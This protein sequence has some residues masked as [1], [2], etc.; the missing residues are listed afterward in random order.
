MDV[1]HGMGRA[2][3]VL[4]VF[5]KMSCDIIGLQ[6]TIKRRSSQSTLLQ[7]GCVVF[8]SGEFGGDGGEGNA[9]GGVGLAGVKS[10]SPVEVRSPEFTSDRLL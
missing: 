10:I 7:A 2:A 8:C 6:E 5:Q 4:G 1:K 9:P 3:D